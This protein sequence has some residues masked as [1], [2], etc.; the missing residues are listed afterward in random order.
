MFLC[1]S[2]LFGTGLSQEPAGVDRDI[3][4]R[5]NFIA[6]RP[7]AKQNFFSATIFVIGNG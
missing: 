6:V 5:E 7:F 3:V 2:D 4:A 1:P